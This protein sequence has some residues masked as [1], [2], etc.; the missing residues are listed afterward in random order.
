VIIQVSLILRIIL[1]MALLT[2]LSL[3]LP[4][5]VLACGGPCFPT[6]S[7]GGAP[8]PPPGPDPCDG[9][10]CDGASGKPV[11]AYTGKEF[12]QVT[13]LTVSGIFPIEVTRKY[14]SQSRYDSPM[15]YGWALL[16][17]K[18]LF[19]Y[20]D[21]SVVVRNDCGVR[22]KYLFSGG[23][24]QTPIGTSNVLVENPDGTFT[25][26]R[27]EGG[28]EFYDLQGK[29]SAIQNAQG[30]RLEFSYE[31][32]GDSVADRLPLT[33]SSP[34]SLDPATPMVVS[35]DYQLEKIEER[36]A[37]GTLTG[38][39]VTFTYDPITGRLETATS[40]DGR[41]VTYVHDETTTAKNGNLITVN[42][43]EGVIHTYLYDDTVGN[44]PHNL[45]SIDEGRGVYVN[46]YNTSDQVTQQTHNNN[47]LTFNYHNGSWSQRTVTET[48]RDATGTTV[49]NTLVIYY[50]F[51]ID[52]YP[53]NTTRTLTDGTVY[54]TE[55]DRYTTGKVSQE[56][57][58]IT[59]VG[60]SKTLV[61]T[62]DFT[63][64]N[65]WNLITEEKVTDPTS[66]EVITKTWEYES[67]WVS[68]EQTVSSLRPTE[69]FRT[70]YTFF[71]DGDGKPENIKDERRR[72]AD[73]SFQTTSY[74]YENGRVKTT[75]FADGQ[76]M[77]NVYTGDELTKVYY[78]VPGTSDESP[79]LKKQ[80]DYDAQG[81]LDTITDA[82]NQVSERVY[83]EL[84]RLGV[85]TNALD[86]DTVYAYTGI[87]LTQVETGRTAADGEGQIVRLSYDNARLTQIE[88]KKSVEGVTPE[89][90]VTMATYTYDSQNNR[91]S[92]TLYRDGTPLTT[93]Y[94]YDALNRLVRSEDPVGNVTQ[95]EYDA[96]GNRTAVISAVN[97]IAKTRRQAS[98]YDAFSRLVSVVED[99]GDGKLNATTLMT[100]DAIGNLLTVTD[101]ESST[102]T[103]TYDRL[104]RRTAV[105]QPMMEMVQYIYNDR[106]QLDYMVNAR[107]HKIDYNYYYWG[108]LYQVQYFA[109]TVTT[110]VDR[111]VTYT[112][113]YNGNIINTFDSAVQVTALYAFTY[114][115]LDRSLQTFT[116]YMAGHMTVVG[117]T[118]DR[119]GNRDSV[120][121]TDNQGTVTNLYGYNK[122]NQVS[123][124]DLD[125]QSYTPEY[126]EDA[127]RLKTLTYP[128]GITVDYQYYNN[129]PIQ[130]ILT[131][132][133]GATPSIIEQLDYVYDAL[134]NV[135][136]M[137]S[138]R[139]GGVHDYAYDTQDHIT[140]AIHP[141][142]TG[143]GTESFNY[144][145]VGNRTSAGYDY[146]AN[147]QI[148]QS[149]G[150]VGYSFDDD[151]NI[152][153]KD[154][155][156][157]NTDTFT[158]NKDSRL[159]QFTDGDNASNNA[160]YQYDPFG[161]RI[162]K[163]VS[164]ITTYYVWNDGWIVAEYN[165][166]TI[167]S[168]SYGYLPKGMNPI[169][170]INP[171]GIKYVHFNHLQFPSFLTNNTENIIWSQTE[172][173]FGESLINEDP[174]G[175]GIFVKFN[176][177][178]AGQ[179]ADPETGLNYNLFR[180]YDPKVGRYITADPIGMSGGI[181]LYAYVS[182]NPLLFIDLNGLNA[183][184]FYND[185]CNDDGG[186]Y[187]CSVA[188]TMCN[189][190]P[191]GAKPPGG[192]DDWVD[193][194]RKCLQTKDVQCDDPGCSNQGADIVCITVIHVECWWECY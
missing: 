136:S 94:G 164:G 61:K 36:T 109:D 71:Y 192:D 165:N 90:W 58:Y 185:R 154:F 156:G 29:L 127:N 81:N 95:F 161:R 49:L 93:L 6:S 51:D 129:G 111:T 12:H 157:G 63:Y 1:L 107:G 57:I 167:R 114:D 18:R 122:L 76:V 170:F 89:E 119:Y 166:N 187:Y 72:R 143:L 190:W 144:D 74:T 15:G 155:G 55:Q 75:T 123:S 168:N 179:Y 32:G 104:S 19:K 180:Y 40:N 31:T 169:Q 139:N 153:S 85:V 67:T 59:P 137:T 84:N 87:N 163:T 99:A 128:N 176:F 73:G 7:S 77:V 35:Y 183:C 8:G 11:A 148:T 106:D 60:G 173:V 27:S 54:H 100:Y 28:Y 140:E 25:V 149:P 124:I 2:I 174:D 17:D 102:T 62:T 151:G 88:R 34:F 37:D 43:L 26:T 22:H 41:V 178:F 194:S 117:N 23:A 116:N 182:A 78:E 92:N 118:Y 24:Y 186:F 125:G 38:N 159:T 103:Y 53:I 64:D 50:Q 20:S 158:H 120:T 131:Q 21:G 39:S 83:D 68:A 189:N 91:S 135:D 82:K 44:D 52:G 134:L 175:D 98:N 14:D 16:V 48:M 113:D 65:P 146:N 56:R 9:Q 130:Q 115:A 162:S 177:R 13:D 3:L 86:Q 79:Y 70:E 112:Y 4:S 152:V 30:H 101:P 121:L 132:S 147:H 141:A 181:N 171:E 110:T 5:K 105:Q 10:C 193:C 191:D 46:V 172:V 133:S 160:S 69:L 108:G 188:P 80:Y 96:L 45:T 126:Y 33:G 150:V 97:D 138:Q 47:T 184:S 145:T 42:G 142:A 66:G